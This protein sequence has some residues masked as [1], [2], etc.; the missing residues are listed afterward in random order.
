MIWFRT[1]MLTLVLLC[2]SGCLPQ[3]WIRISVEY[4]DQSTPIQSERHYGE[5]FAYVSINGSRPLR[6]LVDTGAPVHSIVERTAAEIGLEPS[7]TLLF[8]DFA[9]SYQD[10]STAHVESMQLGG[11]VLSDFDIVIVPDKRDDRVDGVLGMLGLRERTLTLDFVSGE[12]TISDTRLHRDD[13]GVLPFRT[14]HDKKIL[15]PMRLKD[16]RGIVHEYWATLDTGHNSDLLLGP[17]ATLSCLDRG[18]M[19]Y[20]AQAVGVHGLRWHAEYYPTYGPVRVGNMAYEG[21]VAGANQ[22]SNNIGVGL[23]EGCRVAIDWV[24]KLVQIQRLDGATRL[25]ACESLG[26]FGLYADRDRYWAAVIPG[27]IPEQEGLT[28][29][30]SIIRMN[31]DPVDERLD[32]TDLWPIP[33]GVGVVEIEYVDAETSE[34]KR[35]ILPIE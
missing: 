27:S 31:G 28:H 6:M 9:G 2:L 13:P 18:E 21:I 25:I 3:G 17:V 11:L 8:G 5:I 15:I 30:D 22:A 16:K 35:M 23:L 14:T 33:D 12:M 19:A 10:Q 29:H 26:F 7:G 34:T 24:S 32:M 20:R 1:I 4:S